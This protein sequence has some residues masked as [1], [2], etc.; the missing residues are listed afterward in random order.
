VIKT[1]REFI[2]GMAGLVIGTIIMDLMFAI[3]PNPPVMGLL[4]PCTAES[5]ETQRDVLLDELRSI[6]GRTAAEELP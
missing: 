4:L 3:A 1:E 6:E 5:I 2:I